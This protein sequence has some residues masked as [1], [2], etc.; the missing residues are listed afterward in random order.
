VVG[1]F[2]GELVRGLGEGSALGD[3]DGG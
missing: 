3:L 2:D 1:A